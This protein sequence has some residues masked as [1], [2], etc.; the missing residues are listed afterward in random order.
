LRSRCASQRRVGE[1]GRPVERGDLERL[2]QVGDAEHLLRRHRPVAE[3][4]HHRGADRAV[5][6]VVERD[7]TVVVVHR[8]AGA[9]L[10]QHQRG[11]ADLQVAP[12]ALGGGVAGEPG[13]EFG[14]EAVDIEQCA[15]QVNRGGH[16][17]PRCHPAGAGL[18]AAARGRSPLTVA[19]DARP[20]VPQVGAGVQHEVEQAVGGAAVFGWQIHYDVTTPFDGNSAAFNS[21]MPP[22]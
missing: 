11:Q 8:R 19:V 9:V 13:G 1:A 4:Q 15:V 10:H 7:R 22:E 14:I 21:K 18:P 12:V 20:V 6:V 3:A 17:Q 16:E 2:E 5:V